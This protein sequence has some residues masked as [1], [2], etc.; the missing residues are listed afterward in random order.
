MNGV[1]CN[2]TRNVTTN[3]LQYVCNRCYIHQNRESVAHRKDDF[4]E[5]SKNLAR[6]RSENNFV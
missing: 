3:L 4:A 6:Y 1:H 5:V 2:D